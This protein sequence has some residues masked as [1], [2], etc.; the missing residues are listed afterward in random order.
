M[1]K[2][3]TMLTVAAIA[4]AASMLPF[5]NE[6]LAHPGDV[7]HWFEHERAKS[8]GGP[9]LVNEADSVKQGELRD[10]RTRSTMQTL[11]R[12]QG[13]RDCFEEELKRSEGYSPRADCDGARKTRPEAQVGELK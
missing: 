11:S 5:S 9:T 7:H 2:L 4:G 8:D 6:A 3:K 12:A 1:R 10:E 13:V